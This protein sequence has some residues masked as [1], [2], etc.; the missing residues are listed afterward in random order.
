MNDLFTPPFLL[1]RLGVFP[2]LLVTLY[3]IIQ[4]QPFPRYPPSVR[5]AL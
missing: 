3:D 5:V 4:G 1:S 2:L